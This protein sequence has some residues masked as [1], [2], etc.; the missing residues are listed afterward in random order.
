[1]SQ[2]QEISQKQINNL[3]KCYEK[4]QILQAEQLS[5]SMTR[6]FPKHPFG[7]KVLGVIYGMT[8]TYMDDYSPRCLYNLL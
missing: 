7:W 5:L 2:L 8:G 1:M 6:E 3:L 4:G